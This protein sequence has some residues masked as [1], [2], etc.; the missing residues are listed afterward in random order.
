MLADQLLYIDASA[1]VFPSVVSLQGP[2]QASTIN[3]TG[4]VATVKTYLV[5]P[6]VVGVFGSAAVAEA[7]FTHSA[8]DSNDTSASGIS[9][10]TADRV[11]LRLASGPA[12][13]LLTWN[14]AYF[15]ESIDYETQPDTTSEAILA[16]ARRLITPT[17]SLVAQTG[18]EDYESD[19]PGAVAKGW[20]WN[21]GLA[22]TPSPRTSF[23]ATAGERFFGKTYAVDFSHRTRLTT[24]S[25]GYS[26]DVTSTRTEAFLAPATSTAG[27]LDPLFLSN[28]S[29]SCSSSEGG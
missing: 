24:W 20:R 12:Y 23:T 27:Y 4:N 11:T 13:K 29:R 26:E 10:S 1:A 5:S 22:W 3:T 21:A 2:L 6:Y 15:K 7:R 25:A 28:D 8:W 19:L 14:L 17:M 18:Y 16:S 9:N